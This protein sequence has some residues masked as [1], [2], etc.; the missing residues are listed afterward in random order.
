MTAADLR[1][2]YA[3][4]TLQRWIDNGTDLNA[5]L[6]YLRTYMGHSTLSQTAYYIHMLP[7]N[8]LKSPGIDWASFGEVIPEVDVW[9]E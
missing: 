3:S 8:L 9:S 2:R 4:A 7:E 5:K 6:P 1:H